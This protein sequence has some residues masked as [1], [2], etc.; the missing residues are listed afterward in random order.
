M[1][2]NTVERQK[3]SEF[4]NDFIF[5]TKDESMQIDSYFDFIYFR[6]ILD[7]K[8]C[9]KLRQL[10]K[11]VEEKVIFELNQYDKKLLK[12]NYARNILQRH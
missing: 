7:E 9:D 5:N 11:S 12:N 8:E 1:I 3:F 6:D 4:Y 10:I 2:T